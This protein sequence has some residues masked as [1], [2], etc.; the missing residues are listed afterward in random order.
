MANREIDFSLT[1]ADTNRYFCTNKKE[2]LD[3]K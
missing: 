1:W 3:R 2:L